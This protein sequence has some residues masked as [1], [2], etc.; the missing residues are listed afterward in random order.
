[1]ADDDRQYFQCDQ[2][3]YQTPNR[4]TF[5]N[6]MNSHNNVR[7]Y[8]CDQCDARFV[9]MTVLIGHQKHKHS[10]KDQHKVCSQCGY[11]AKTNSSLNLHIRVQHQLKGI[12]PYKCDY[13]DF[14]CATGG[15]CRKHIMGKHK[16]SPV[17]YTCDKEYLEKARN[18]RKAG[19]TNQLFE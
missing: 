16:G 14:R 12:K 5:A 4:K 7:N 8:I 3:T 6:H 17:H 19:N 13:C 2:C 9:T 1:M 10:T 15:N 18:E 11:R